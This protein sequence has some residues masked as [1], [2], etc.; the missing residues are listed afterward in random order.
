MTGEGADAMDTNGFSAAWENAMELD[1][2]DY[3]ETYGKD[4][5]LRTDPNGGVAL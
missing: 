4:E 1:W 3:A 5:S 2:K